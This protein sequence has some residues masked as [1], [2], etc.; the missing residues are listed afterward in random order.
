MN[1]FGLDELYISEENK[2]KFIK[3]LLKQIDKIPNDAKNI[4]MSGNYD[5]L[6]HI[7]YYSESQEKEVKHEN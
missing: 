5:G 7:T 3:E 1:R 6:V 4:N 2:G